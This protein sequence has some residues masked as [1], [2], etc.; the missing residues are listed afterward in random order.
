MGKGTFADTAVNGCTFP[1][2]FLSP[3]FKFCQLLPVMSLMIQIN[4]HIPILF[5]LILVSGMLLIK[6]LLFYINIC[7]LLFRR[8]LCPKYILPAVYTLTKSA[9]TTSSGGLLLEPYKSYVTA[10]LKGG[11][12]KHY[13]WQ[14]LK[15]SSVTIFFSR[16]F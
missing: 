12:R 7:N 3:L 9:T 10:R 11:Y 4:S 15:S 13:Y 14:L 6:L 2:C 8:L 5:V 1:F 16:L